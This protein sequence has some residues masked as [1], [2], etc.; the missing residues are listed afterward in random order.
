M[1]VLFGETE[2]PCCRSCKNQPGYLANITIPS[3]CEQTAQCA[4]QGERCCR[5]TRVEGCACPEGTYFD[6]K[7]CV[8][9]TNECDKPCYSSSSVTSTST[10]ATR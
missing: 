6:G 3:T 10:T 7:K 2:L 9:M 8:N 4:A 5:G 1:L